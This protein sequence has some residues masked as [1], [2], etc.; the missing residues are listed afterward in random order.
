LLTYTSETAAAEKLEAMVKLGIANS[1]MKDFSDLEVPRVSF[2][3]KNILNVIQNTFEQP[4]PNCRRWMP[5]C[6][7]ARLLRR[8][9]LSSS[10]DRLLT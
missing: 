7:C 10:M 5:P 9:Q 4:G 8:R 2:D 3:G 1:R 6:T